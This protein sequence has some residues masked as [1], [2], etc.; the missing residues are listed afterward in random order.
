[1][2][3]SVVRM[4]KY[5]W[6]QMQSRKE[7]QY[8]LTQSEVLSFVQFFICEIQQW[9]PKIPWI[10]L[11]WDDSLPDQEALVHDGILVSV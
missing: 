9:L 3:K 2:V 4:Y 1:M 5:F 6:R 11:L 10:Q 7:V 8:A